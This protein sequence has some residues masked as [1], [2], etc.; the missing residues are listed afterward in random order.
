MIKNSIP[1]S[2][3]MGLVTEPI[4]ALK[5]TL[6]VKPG[7]ETN[8]D[9]ILSVGEEKEKVKE[10]IQKYQSSQ[11]VKTEFELSKAKVEAESRYLRIKGKEIAIYQKMLSYII[12]DNPMKA[13]NMRK[14]SQ[15]S[16]KQ[17]ELWKYGISG[18]LPIILVKIKDVNDGYVIREVL[19]AYEFFRTRNVKTEIVILDEEKHSYENYVKEEIENNILNEHMAYLKNI[20]GGIFTISKVEIDK[21]DIELLEFV[22]SIIIDSKKGGIENAIKDIEEEY[23]EKYK[24]ISKEETKTMQIEESGD[25]NI[26][27]NTENLKYYNEYGG[28]SEDGKEYFIS[29]NK[30]NRLPTVWSHIIANKKFGCVLTENMGGYSWYLNSRL[31]RISSWE[32]NPSYDIPSEIIYLKDKENQKAWSLGLNP[33]PD[34]KNYNIIY[35]FGYAKYIHKSDGIEQELITFVPENEA[36]KIGI[37][38][39]KNMTP[40][41]K[42]IKLYYYIKPVIG[43]DEIKSNGFITTKFDKNNNVIIAK[44]LYRNELENTK[45]Y[46]SCS[47]N[48]LSYTGDKNFF[49]GQGGISNPEALKK[50]SLNN[51]NSLGRKAVI[52]YETEIEIESFANKEISIILG[53]EENVIDCKNIA[54]KY[55]KIANCKQELEKVKSNWREL[56]DRVQVYTPLES[57]NIILNGWTQY[58]TITSRLLGRSGYYQ[59]GGAYGFRDQLQD[60]LGLKYLEPTILKKQIIK[61]S[62]HQFIEGDVEHWWH[63]ETRKRHSN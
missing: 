38:S 23:L 4:I 50:V 1:L 26:L 15:N 34:D 55:S 25:I 5:R 61:H 21:K 30:E 37:L 44:N 32:N 17:E 60:T 33:M 52:A 41:R 19:K 28:F 27:Q 7:E 40:N 57:I 46:V 16:Y 12:F 10:N 29:I 31:N 24:Q 53:A 11:N 20:K 45:I 58:Q 59:S 42:K 47:E 2:K 49:L 54:Y 48:I 18:D 39:L 14:I 36:C 22:A 35:G 9:F 63:D 56:L 13:Q 3:K 43:E 8:I 62:K 51:E 6:K